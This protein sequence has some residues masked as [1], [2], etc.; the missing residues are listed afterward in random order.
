MQNGVVVHNDGMDTRIDIKKELSKPASLAYI[1]ELLA[2]NG[3]MNRSRLGIAVCDH[4]GFRDEMGRFRLTGCLRA[5]RKLE[6]EKQ[7]KLPEVRKKAGSHAP[8]RLGEAVALPNEVPCEVSSVRDLRLRLVEKSE[9]QAIWNELMSE[10]PLGC[11]QLVGRQLRYLISSEHGWLGGL[12]FAASAL[13]LSDRDEWIGW[14]AEEQRKYL[15]YV[16]GMSRFLIRP[17]V[18]CQNL[19]SKVLGMSMMV[20]GDDFASRYGYR[21]WLVETFVDSDYSGVCY[22]AAN[23]IDIGKTR[24]RGRHDRLKEYALSKKAIYIYVLDKSFRQQ[25]GLSCHGRRVW[26]NPIHTQ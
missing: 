10:H 5:L 19:A 12:G 25:M 7:V 26:M 15:P 24:G 20:L 9:E 6:A 18:R 2:G 11:T 23:W 13:Q 17:S 16:V 21:P 4:F 14:N 3:A 1:E 22:R 8:R